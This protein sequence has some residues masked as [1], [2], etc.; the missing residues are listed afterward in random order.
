MSAT[1]ASSSPGSSRP[2]AAN[3]T[4]YGSS[5]RSPVILSAIVAPTTTRAISRTAL[6]RFQI[7]GRKRH[8]QPNSSITTSAASRYQPAVVRSVA[9]V[10][11][12]VAVAGQ[13]APGQLLGDECRYL[14]AVC[15]AFDARH[16]H[17]HDLAH[18]AHR[19]RAAL[20]DGLRHQTRQL[21]RAKLLGQIRA[22]DR[23][24]CLLL[25]GGC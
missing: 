20:V 5:G 12:L 7:C 23:D 8:S 9:V 17:G 4:T 1:P 15:P 3:G 13:V 21:V 6:G 11:G 10:G 14:L 22:D 25:G 18:V 2:T 16:E 24:L 19:G